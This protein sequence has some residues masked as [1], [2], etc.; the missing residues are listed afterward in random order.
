MNP[1]SKFGTRVIVAGAGGAS[2]GTETL[3][4]LA[5]SG[6]YQAIAA[7]IA[8]L[9]YGL[10][11]REATASHLLRASNY[12][13]DL[14]ECCH[15]EQARLVLPSAEPTL[16][17]ISGANDRLRDKGIMAVHNRPEVI[18]AC[19]DKSATFAHLEPE[20]LIVD[21]VLAVGDSEFQ[22]KCLDKMDDV[23]HSGRTIL[24]VSHN[25]Q[26]IT[27]LCARCVF[28][29][30]GSVRMDGMPLRVTQAYLKTGSHLSAVREWPDLS[31]APGDDVIRLCAV[32]A[33]SESGEPAEAFDIRHPVGIEL[34]YEILK[35]GYLLLP[36]FLTTNE[37]GVEMFVANDM[38]REW[39]GRRRPVG[40]Y[41][42]TGWI[43]GNLLV[44]GTV[45]IGTALMTLDPEIVHGIILDAIEFRVLFPAGAQDTARGDFRN[46]SPS[47][48]QPMLKW[49]T[50]Y[51]PRSE[52]AALVESEAG[53]IIGT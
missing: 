36:H 48:V 50:R 14:I 25:M 23:G 24:F 45:T 7:D 12:L 31:Q 49:T 52:A 3:K 17:I 39:R 22:K 18:R 34:E 43:P 37:S 21:E 9:A 26:A 5:L 10:Y 16:K 2:L 6:R 33:I 13:D 20:I 46:V 29:E 47:V 35:P 28:M 11:Q 38:D 8:P 19:S 53:A 1:E 27:R 15:R 40:R 44:E 30:R 41:V 42:S 32:R 4:A 51:E